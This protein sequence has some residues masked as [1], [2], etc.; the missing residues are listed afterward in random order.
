MFL[1]S[2]ILP[3]TP[4]SGR[5]ICL[6]AHV[7]GLPCPGCGLGRSFVA[8]TH[9]AWYEALVFHPLGPLVY[10]ALAVVLVRLLVGAVRRRPLRPW[11]PQRLR[12]P[13]AWLGVA[14]VV[15][16]WAARLLGML[17]GPPDA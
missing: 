13:A 17:P 5:T 14:T 3:W 15:L 11:L 7:T 12:W 9:G 4:L 16:V 8:L 2:A 6:F 10:L 1:A